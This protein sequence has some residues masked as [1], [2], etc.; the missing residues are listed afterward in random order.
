[1]LIQGIFI[2]FLTIFLFLYIRFSYPIIKEY[3]S[4]IALRNKESRL[5]YPELKSIK[6]NKRH[7]LIV[8]KQLTNL[9]KKLKHYRKMVIF[10]QLCLGICAGIILGI[11]LLNFIKYNTFLTS[12]FPII[13][14]TLIM[15]PFKLLCYYAKL[16]I[17]QQVVIKK[18]YFITNPTNDLKLIPF[19][20]EFIVKFNALYPRIQK[21]L[22]L[23]FLLLICISA[24]FYLYP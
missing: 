2:L 23:T 22:S 12:I 6:E 7:Q 5:E 11:F 10:L 4:L 9:D 1:M 24:Y 15:L 3:S 13:L 18:K 19:K 21:F 16:F 17:N 8:I 14:L 20:E